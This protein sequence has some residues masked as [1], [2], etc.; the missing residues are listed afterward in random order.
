MKRKKRKLNLDE[1][2][3]YRI[4]Y[5]DPIKIKDVFKSVFLPFI[6]CF[7]FVF[8]LFFKWYLGLI[9]GLIGMFYS[10]F[11]ILPTNE[12][13][14]YELKSFKERNKFVN[15]MTQILTNE[16][17]TV[18]QAL[19][20][21]KG[22]ANGEFK[23]DLITLQTNLIDAT[24]DSVQKSFKVIENKY[25]T[26]VMFS[27]Y[28]EQLTTAMIEG[29]NNLDTLKDVKTYHNMI[30]E[31]QAQFFIEKKQKQHDFNFM[32]RIALI[33]LLFIIFSFGVRQYID[34]YTNG[35]IGWVTSSIYLFLISKIYHSFRKRFSD[36]SVMEVKI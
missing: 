35:I 27:Q 26:D 3:A 10:F 29:R 8:L 16:D 14:D 18:L 9:G 2:N 22:R 1:I 24:G 19:E 33:F 15:N 12:K 7:L 30:K 34:N 21:V 11:Y 17:R 13:R 28:I 20:I 5:G 31:R 32:V 23:R 6:V 25:Q 4:A 36:D